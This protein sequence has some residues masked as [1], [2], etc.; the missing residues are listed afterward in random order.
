[1]KLGEIVLNDELAFQ[2][3]SNLNLNLR[4][5]FHCVAGKF[6]EDTRF[7]DL[8]I[9]LEEEWDFYYKQQMGVKVEPSKE[10]MSDE[11]LVTRDYL[12]SNLQGIHNVI[13]Q[14]RRSQITREGFISD[15]LFH[16]IAALKG[17]LPEEAYTT[18]KSNLSES[19][20]KFKELTEGL[21][22]ENEEQTAKLEEKWKR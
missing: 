2:L 12:L 5:L 3:I 19:Q 17:V 16:V 4:T 8:V 9:G 13:N 18:L 15:S 1:M 11:K 20:S 21:R 22:K 10:N 7:L 6:P 14:N